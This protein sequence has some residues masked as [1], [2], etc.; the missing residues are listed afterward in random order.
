MRGPF[1]FFFD[2]PDFCKIVMAL[3]TFLKQW[4]GNEDGL[5]RPRIGGPMRAARFALGLR[6]VRRLDLGSPP[7]DFLGIRRERA[8]SDSPEPEHLPASFDASL[9]AVKPRP[10][11]KCRGASRDRKGRAAIKEGE[12]R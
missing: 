2:D 6:R 9:E 1:V 7:V 11:P 10:K 5:A 4:T 3:P 8:S 12:P